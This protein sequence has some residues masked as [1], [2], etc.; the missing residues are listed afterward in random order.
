MELHN[1]GVL[2]LLVLLSAVWFRNKFAP[3][4]LTYLIFPDPEHRLLHLLLARERLA[5][6]EAKWSP[7]AR[8]TGHNESVRTQG[9]PGLTSTATDGAKTEP[10]VHREA[11]HY[12]SVRTQGGHGLT[13]AATEGAKTEPKVHREAGHYESVRT[14]GGHGLTSAATDGAKTEPK[15]HC[16]EPDLQTC[17]VDHPVPGELLGVCY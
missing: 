15:V 9:G 5:R 12:E 17:P 1:Y 14:H 11:G 8:E 3:L 16:G 13:S 4:P 6:F 7:A 2:S 10:K